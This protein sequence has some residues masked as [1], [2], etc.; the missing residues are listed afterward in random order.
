MAVST[1]DG[2]ICHA[3]K[4]DKYSASKRVQT[5]WEG[6]GSIERIT[7]IR[8]GVCPTAIIKHV[9]LKQG[10]DSSVGHQRKR[11]SYIVETEFYHRYGAQLCGE[12]SPC[13]IPQ[14]YASSTAI[15]DEIVLVL[16]DLD[17]AG[18]MLRRHSLNA[19]EMKASLTWLAHFH[20]HFMQ[21]PPAGIWEVGTYWHLATRQEEYERMRPG[22]LKREAA[23]L[24]Q[25]LL[26]AA[27]QTFVHGDA[28]PANFCFAADGRVAAVDF[29]YVGQGCG[30][31]DVAYL[32][33]GEGAHED[34]MLDHYFGQ[35]RAA[36]AANRRGDIPLCCPGG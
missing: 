25:Q 35:L 30:M 7:N 14:A 10:R 16:E 23:N 32:L 5:L 24:D 6:Y 17:A 22:R 2:I 9:R 18:F 19:S 3:L 8:N 33:H 21:R 34:A 27:F 26:D 29:Q 11:R 20:A 4:S 13:R 15:P 36:L 1:V 31:R 12:N 28:K